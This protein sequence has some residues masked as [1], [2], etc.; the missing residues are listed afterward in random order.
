MA[1]ELGVLGIKTML[2]EPGLISTSLTGSHSGQKWVPRSD[3]YYKDIPPA[4]FHL[5][6]LLPLVFH[7]P[8]LSKC[9][10]VIS[11]TTDLFDSTLLFSRTTGMNLDKFAKRTAT[12]IIKG[13]KYQSIGGL[14]TIWWLMSFMPRVSPCL[15]CH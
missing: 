15:C 14:S 13:R 10:C 7:H 9:R 5:N 6:K 12:S 3:S 1:L 2:L 8:W 4:H 11:R